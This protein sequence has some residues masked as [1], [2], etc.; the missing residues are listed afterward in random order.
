MPNQAARKWKKTSTPRGPGQPRIDAA[1]PLAHRS[2]GLPK[3]WWREVDRI[4]QGRGIKSAA[5]V[6]A[7]VGIYLKRLKKLERAVHTAAAKR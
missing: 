2:V 6:R 7:A 1:A 5:L 4:A 3:T